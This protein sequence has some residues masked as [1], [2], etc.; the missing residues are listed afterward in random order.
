MVTDGLR[1]LGQGSSMGPGFQHRCGVCGQGL[2]VHTRL[3]FGALCPVQATDEDELGHQDT[4]DR[5]KA[6]ENQ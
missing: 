2:S 1:D 5:G 3:R 6:Q 4:E